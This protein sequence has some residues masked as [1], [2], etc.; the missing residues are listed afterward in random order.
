MQNSELPLLS[1]SHRTTKTSALSGRADS[2]LESVLGGGE[3]ERKTVILV[4]MAVPPA[5]LASFWL[6]Q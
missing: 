4:A 3:E 5:V 2:L 6:Q 1:R